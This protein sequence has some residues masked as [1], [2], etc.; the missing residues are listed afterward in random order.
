MVF[1]HCAQDIIRA[2]QSVGCFL[3]FVLISRT[4]TNSVSCSYRQCLM[5]NKLIIVT[6]FL[7]RRKLCKSMH[8]HGTTLTIRLNT[9]V[10]YNYD[11]KRNLIPCYSLKMN[12]K[13]NI[14]FSEKYIRRCQIIL[15][16]IPF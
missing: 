13:F 9:R 2:V 1:V 14:A 16:P 12:K 10:F 5:C 7:K 6:R 4:V 8:D 11:D 15:F 3:P